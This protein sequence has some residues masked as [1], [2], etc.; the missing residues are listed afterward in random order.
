[1]TPEELGFVRVDLGDGDY[2]Y[3]HQFGRGLEVALEPCTY[4][5]Y[6]LAVY[7]D[8]LLLLQKNLVWIHPSGRIL[9][10]V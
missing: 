7:Q 5:Q 2:Y 8:R 10:V 6:H 9:F 1:M 4:G 3:G